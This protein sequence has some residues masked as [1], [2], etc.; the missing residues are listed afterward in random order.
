MVDIQSDMYVYIN[1]GDAV[2]KLSINLFYKRW[3]IIS[4]VFV[5]KYIEILI[6]DLF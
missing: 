6:Y 2:Y 3:L 4:V 5:V 1:K